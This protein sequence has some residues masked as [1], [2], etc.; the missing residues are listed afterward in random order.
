MTGLNNFTNTNWKAP[1]YSS[2]SMINTFVVD[3]YS[4][5]PANT[6]LIYGGKTKDLKTSVG[7]CFTVSAPNATE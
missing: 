6:K 5:N 7:N 3:N 2:I 1:I 4:G